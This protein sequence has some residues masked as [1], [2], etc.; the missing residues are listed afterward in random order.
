MV[1][2]APDRLRWNVNDGALIY[3]EAF[4]EGLS[5][6]PALTLTDW[7][8][9]YRILSGKGS[10]EPG[11]YRMERTPF[12]EE[13]ADC[14][15][16]SSPVER[17]VLMKSTQIGASELGFNW[18]GFVAHIAPGPMMMVQPTT[19]LAEKVSKQRI[20]SMIAETPVL[21]KVF[22]PEKSRT[23][24]QTVLLKE[25]K[26][27]VLSITGANSAVGLRS[28]PVKFL[29]C[30]E[31]SAYPADLD[32]E[33]DPVS[34]AEERTSTFS[35]RKKIFLTSTPKMKGFCRI[36]LEYEGSDQRRYMVPCPH[37]GTCDWL[38]WRNLKWDNDDPMTTRYVCEHCQGEVFEH[39]KTEMFRNKR[40]GGNAEWVPTAPGNGRTQGYHLSALY[41]PVGWKSWA[42]LVEKFLKAKGDAPLLKSFVNNT[43]GETWED[44]YAARVG[45]GALRDRVEI[46]EP[47][48]APKGVLFVTA[49]VDIQDNRFAVTVDG[50]GKDE[51]NWTISHQEV[52]GNPAQ[53][54]F[55]TQLENVLSQPIAHELAADL[56]LRAVCIDSG[57]H[58]THE[59]YQFCRRNR[60]RSWLAVKGQSQKGKPAI[61]K[62]SKVDVNW[63]GQVLKHGAEVFPVGTDTIKDVIYSRLKHNQP[64]PGYLHFHAGLPEDYFDQLTAEKQVVRY[65][66]GF[67][68][69]EWTKKAGARNEALD[70]KVYSYAA[71]QFVKNQFNP[72]T[73][74]EQ[75]EK[76][77]VLKPGEAGNMAKQDDTG[78]ETRQ[79]S[80]N[81]VVLRPKRKNFLTS[82]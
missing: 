10:A 55:W 5:P 51:E 14:L 68:I 45:A 74:W 16:P 58:F 48:V 24:G 60:H 28:M 15:S 11:P 62:A 39:H 59:V 49:G 61:G 25:F 33:G 47:G 37:C 42:S 69:K 30:D 79:A 12:L 4:L 9:R 72:K 76:R 21:Q 77:L 23:A 50:W 18:I 40:M 64:G 38:K 56:K 73:V 66:K 31:V 13:I 2:V 46:Y 67:P 20:S 82:W 41:S 36:E 70:T 54:E 81:K 65:V 52:M 80:Q 63:K 3:R 7:S 26:G 8:N 35:G 75:F 43:L 22:G 44:E 32:D 27:G 78:A 19:E 17:V 6:D 34:L 1:E 29:F 53:P 71:C 57:G